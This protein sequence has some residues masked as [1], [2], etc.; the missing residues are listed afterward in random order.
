MGWRVLAAFAICILVAGCSSP[1]PIGESWFPEFEF[2]TA[3][4]GNFK[5]GADEVYYAVFEQRGGPCLDT[6]AYVFERIDEDGGRHGFVEP[7]NW[8]WD[9]SRDPDGWTRH[10]KGPKENWCF[11][12]LGA[13]EHQ[14][15]VKLFKVYEP[16]QGTFVGQLRVF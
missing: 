14:Q 2:K 7:K 10:A 1:G 4:S 15:G 16:N 6:S 9:A 8:T 5:L 11:G 12:E 3:N 13:L